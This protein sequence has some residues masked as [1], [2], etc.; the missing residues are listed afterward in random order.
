MDEKKVIEDYYERL[1]QK[2]KKEG[3]YDPYRNSI[4][5]DSSINSKYVIKK[6]DMETGEMID[7]YKT[8]PTLI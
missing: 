7:K 8:D 4:A 5:W 1:R 2:Q 3:T 6:E